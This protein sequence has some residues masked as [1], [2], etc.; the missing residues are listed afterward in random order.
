MATFQQKNITVSLT[1]FSLILLFFLL[2]TAQ[3]VQSNNFNES[4][5][6]QL[7]IMVAVLAVCAT[8]LAMI[9]THTISATAN[10]VQSGEPNFEFDDLVDERDQRID[11]KG[12][13]ITYRITSLGTFIA[14]L[15]FV[16]GQSP[17]IMFSLLILFGLIAQIVGDAMRLR[18]YQQG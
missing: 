9:V 16:L 11:H 12:T 17:L 14:M 4:S 6:T 7:W 10:A 15:T 13:H 3:L 5:V 8:V 18:L 2:R 1:T